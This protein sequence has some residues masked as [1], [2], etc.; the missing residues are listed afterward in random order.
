MEIKTCEQ[1]VLAEL[2][3]LKWDKSSLMALNGQLDDK[4]GEL[5]SE[6]DFIRGAV[7]NLFYP[8]GEIKSAREL[9]TNTYNILRDFA[10]GE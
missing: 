2:E 6:L 7:R 5:T 4:V 10:K 1:Y 9:D 8:N 3:Q